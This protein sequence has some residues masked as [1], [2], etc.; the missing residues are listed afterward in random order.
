MTVNH[1]TVLYIGEKSDDPLS[2]AYVP[3]LFTFTPSSKK[4]KSQQNLDR[5]EAAKRR[6]EEKD[7]TEAADILL[8]FASQKVDDVEYPSNTACVATQTSFDLTA[9][10]YDY[11]KKTD[12]L[13]A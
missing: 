10:E 6:Q 2:P 13:A 8:A 9:L 1:L 3:S 4:I 12:Q 5:Y 7:K 11:Q